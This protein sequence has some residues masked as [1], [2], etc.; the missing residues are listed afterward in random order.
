MHYT[1]MNTASFFFWKCK[2]Q[3][4]VWDHWKTSTYHNMDGGKAATIF[5]PRDCIHSMIWDIWTKYEVIQ[6]FKIR[7][8]RILGTQRFLVCRPIQNGF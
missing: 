7:G 2:V 4:T 1:Q 8:S 3:N 5:K 6:L